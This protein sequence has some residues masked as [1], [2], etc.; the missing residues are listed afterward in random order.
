MSTATYGGLTAEQ[1]TFYELAMLPRAVA[2]F[3]HAYW[4]QVGVHPKT[5]I[6]Q[7]KGDTI[8]WRL[9]SSFSAVTTALTEGVTPSS[10][11]LT[12]TSVTGTVAEYGSYVRYTRKL[13][14]MGIDQVAAAASE[15]L[16]EQ[17]GDSIDQITRDV[18]IAGTTVQYAAN[19]A[20]RGT[21]AAGDKLT[22]AES[23]EALATLKA[24][25]ARPVVDGLFAVIIH[26]YTEYD[27]LTDTTFQ[28]VFNYAYQRGDT[29][30]PYLTGFVGDALGARWYSSSNAKVFSGEGAS[31]IDV[32]GSLFL[33]KGSFGVGGLAGY[34]PGAVDAKQ[35]GNDANATGERVRPIQL[36]DKPFGSAGAD[37]PLEQRA[38]IAWYTTYVTKRLREPFMLR[39]EHDVTID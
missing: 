39:L 32:Y 1:R 14:A 11:S 10:Q 13:A 6:P 38:S 4:G 21:V 30:N 19:R 33:G 35:G 36:I 7:H 2:N 15:A 20:G 22:A 23:L 18:I 27:I 8:N 37:D 28:N 16:G 34:V 17:S 25:N 26:P 29:K 31:G 9:L 5:E 12:L 3:V 24:N